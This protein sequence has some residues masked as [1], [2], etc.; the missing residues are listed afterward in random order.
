MIP[1]SSFK[2]ILLVNFFVICVQGSMQKGRWN[3][4]YDQRFSLLQLGSNHQ[5]GGCR[6]Y[7]ARER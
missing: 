5:R 3:Q 4:I 7:R 2:I 6:G 1:V